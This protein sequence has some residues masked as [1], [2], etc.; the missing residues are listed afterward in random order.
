MRKTKI[1]ATLGPATDSPAVLRDLI[2]AGVNV[3]RL[4]MSHAAHDWVRR[5][6][7][8]I[9]QI[10]GEL[11]KP[12]AILMD[13]QGPAIRTG[14]LPTNLDLKI[15]DTFTFTV[16]GHVSVEERSVDT[17]Y[18]SLV[19]D[20]KVGDIVLVDNGVIEMMVKEKRRQ[21]LVCEVLTPGVMG[22]RRHINLP[23]IKVKL[24]A[25]TDKDLGDLKVGAE[26]DVDLIAL[27]FVRE[28]ADLDLLRQTLAADGRAHIGIIAKIE[29]QS[30]VHN[31]PAIISAA[32]GIMVAR[33]DLGIE[34]P[35]DELPI[36]QRNIINACLDAGKP[37]IV[38]THMLESM[39][40]NPLPTR[41]EITD[42]A[43]AVFE[44]ADAIMLSGETTVGQYPVKCVQVLDKV[45]TTSERHLTNEYH[46]TLTLTQRREQAAAAAVHLA[47]Q[48]QADGLLIFTHS[49][50]NAHLCAALRPSPATIFAVTPDAG[51]ARR[52]CLNY[53][54]HPIVMPLK[55][56]HLVNIDLARNIM[57]DRQLLPEGAKLVVLTD[58]ITHENR[59]WTVQ[60]R[61]LHR[62]NQ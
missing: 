31:L 37:V 35:Y 5:V 60:L 24:P 13:T 18:D 3:F 10:A 14:D 17:N 41:A 38:A 62:Y 22:S 47:N 29:D 46:S 44:R 50:L 28:A 43:N 7:P 59:Y 34:W 21:E 58:Q 48:T 39:I 33:G 30:A 45:A 55:D 19:D 51:L 53:A 32:D 27:S 9:R 23:G 54:V 4:N 12:V 8:T 36:V 1:I 2:L 42:V 6:V 61:T 11:R 15:G 56:S 52:L 16:R 40:H 25:L 20:I 49:G 57:L 26:L